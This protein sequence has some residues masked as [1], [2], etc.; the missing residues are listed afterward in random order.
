MNSAKDF[1]DWWPVLLVV[2]GW[3]VTATMQWTN[4]NNKIKQNADDIQEKASLE[5]LNG[6]GQRVEGIKN[7]CANQTGRMDRFEREVNELRQLAQG[8]SDKMTRVD[9]G[10]ADLSDT[11]RDGNIALGVQLGDLTKSIHLMDKNLGNRLTRVETVQKIE[12][13]IGPLPT[14]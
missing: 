12:Q 13:K 6:M 7:D 4:L 10:V 1:L 3:I 8:A 14:E 9:K 11:V 2:L 5:Q